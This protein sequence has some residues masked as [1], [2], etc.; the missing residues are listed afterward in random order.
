MQRS[1]EH[2][3]ICRAQAGDRN[4]YVALI[5]CHGKTIYR[6][7][8]ALTRNTHAAEDLTQDVYLKAWVKLKSFKPGTYFRAWLVRIARNTFL[9]DRRRNRFS[10]S[11]EFHLAALKDRELGPVAA[12]LARETSSL[13]EA[14]EAKLPANFRAAFRLRTREDLPFQEVARVLA[15][16][17]ATA[18]WQVFQARHLL[19]KRLRSLR[20]LEQN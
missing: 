4:A 13:V 5:E 11:N 1:E 2:A 6:L 17:P 20:D 12:L 7:L 9:N 18:R 14:A 16:P 3:L 10:G 8:L 19:R 15:L